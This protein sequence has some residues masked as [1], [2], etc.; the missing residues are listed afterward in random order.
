MHSHA[1]PRCVHS[2]AL[3]RCVPPPRWATWREEEAELAAQQIGASKAAMKRA[4]AGTK[5]RGPQVGSEA[6]RLFFRLETVAAQAIKHV[7]A[8]GPIG[9][10]KW[11]TDGGSWEAELI[12][13]AGRAAKSAEP[14][15]FRERQTVTFLQKWDAEGSA[16]LRCVIACLITLIAY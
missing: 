10:D 14:P 13:P 2:H 8:S 11:L 7:T 9:A 15:S 3:P 4:K 16:I 1:L 12:K 5:F 6:E